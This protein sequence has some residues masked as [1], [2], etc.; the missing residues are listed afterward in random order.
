MK[1]KNMM[2]VNFENKIIL[3]FPLLYKYPK[4]IIT[5]NI[6]KSL[7]FIFNFRG[8]KADFA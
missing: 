6:K 8:I 7:D 4:A 5:L 3:N 2:K 1:G